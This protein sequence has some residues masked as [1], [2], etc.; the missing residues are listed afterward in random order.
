MGLLSFVFGC[1]HRDGAQPVRQ[2]FSELSAQ[3]AARLQHQRGVVAQAAK[4]RYDTVTLTNGL[5]A[6]GEVTDTNSD[7]KR[8]IP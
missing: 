1:W 7:T 5:S 2:K 6:F 3:D 4:Q 8:M